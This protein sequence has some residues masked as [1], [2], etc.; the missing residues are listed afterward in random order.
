MAAA[1]AA[2]LE[3]GAG[4]S[5]PA[6][7]AAAEAASSAGRAVDYGLRGL[8]DVAQKHDRPL[9]EISLGEDLT[10]LGLDLKT[11]NLVSTLGL[12]YADIPSSRAPV[13]DLPA[14]F[15]VRVPGLRDDHMR[16]MDDSTLFYAF[17]SMPL[18]M[19]QLAATRELYS[20]GWM[21]HMKSKV[22]VRKPRAQ[23]DGSPSDGLE[24][25]YPQEWVVKPLGQDSK[26]VLPEVMPADEVESLFAKAVESFSSADKSAASGA[27]AS[28]RA[29]K[30]SS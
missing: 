10:K 21:L 5:G 1:S 27:S 3:A 23:A 6:T 9:S 4:V 14:S 24:M 2:E 26:S 16:W 29:G 20:R 7:A 13:V 8:L 22:W 19:V 18:D 30:P 15:R 11:P 17:Y 12:P 25:F 28:S